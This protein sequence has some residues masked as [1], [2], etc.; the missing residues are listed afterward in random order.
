MLVFG[1]FVFVWS[2]GFLYFALLC[3]VFSLRFCTWL[4]LFALFFLFVC[5]SVCAVLLLL[6]MPLV[7]F[8]LNLL[9]IAVCFTLFDFG[10]L[11]FR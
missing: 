3:T 9:W 8:I 1:V 7:S 2:F 5:S 4:D 6:Y 11:P 10:P